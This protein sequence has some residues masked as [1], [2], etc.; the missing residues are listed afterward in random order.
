MLTP[1]PSRRGGGENAAACYFHDVCWHCQPAFGES[2]DTCEARKMLESLSEEIDSR[3][4][5]M[6]DAEQVRVSPL[7]HT[8]LC[9]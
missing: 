1:S 3:E 4:E 6:M 7:A 2:A 9:P 5:E 8:S